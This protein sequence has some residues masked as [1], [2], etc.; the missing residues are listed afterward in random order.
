MEPIILPYRGKKPVIDPSAYVA[1][2]AVIVGDVAIRAQSSVWFGCVVR[3]DV[4]SIR[5]GDRTNIQDGSIVHVTR[6]K[7]SVTM[8]SDVTIAHSATVH[9]CVIED[10]VLVGM[11]ATILDGAR[12]GPD[13]IVGA[14]CLVPPGFE[15]PAGTLVT[16]V[17]ARIKRD[18][19]EDER[20]H[21]LWYANNYVNYRLNYM[22][23]EDEAQF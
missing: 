17:P 18:L 21:I 14:G 23:R 22:G 19:T 5:I 9:G 1:P 10:R 15:V 4:H 6:G 3:G 7:A 13:A 16:G 8:G 12:V 2:G 20:A 11:S